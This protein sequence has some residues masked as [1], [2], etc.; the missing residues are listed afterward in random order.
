[1]KSIAFKLAVA[2]LAAAC[3]SCAGLGDNSSEVSGSASAITAVSSDDAAPAEQGEPEIG[4]IVNKPKPPSLNLFPD[5]E[6]YIPETPLGGGVTEPGET[7]MLFATTAGET[8]IFDP[9]NAW[10]EFF[11]HGGIAEARTSRDALESI[12]LAVAEAVSQAGITEITENLQTVSLTIAGSLL[13][14]PTAW[15]VEMRLESNSDD[16]ARFYF[17]NATTGLLAATYIVQNDAEANPVKGLFAFVDSELLRDGAN[18]GLRVL[19]LAFDF[20][21]AG[22]NILVTREER[23]HQDLPLYYVYQTH[24][25]CSSETADCVGEYLEITNASPNRDSLQNDIRF[26]WN[27]V[28]QAVCLGAM[29][30]AAHGATSLTTYGFVNQSGGLPTEEAVTENSCT[31]PEPHWNGQTFTSDH[32]LLRYEDTSPHGG[33]GGRYYV[34]GLSKTGWDALTPDHIDTWLDATKF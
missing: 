33:T 11:V 26:S 15:G 21:N 12:G 29:D 20:A 4:I 22:G 34:D 24:Q 7:Q 1:M 17:R 5:F 27:E 10:N 19:A 25:Q 32:L 3:F 30:Y 13:G 16:Y 8:R 31:L 23:Y 28:S 9:I 18:A 2:V 6:S 14:S